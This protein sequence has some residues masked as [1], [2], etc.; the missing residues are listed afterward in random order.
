[1]R[2]RKDLLP[3]MS[4]VHVAALAL[5]RGFSSEKKTARVKSAKAGV[6]VEPIL[7][8]QLDFDSMVGENACYLAF[9][10]EL[11]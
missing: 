3:E 7:A 6:E 2:V 9:G 11:A 10:K 4:R 5:Q 8:Y 1:M